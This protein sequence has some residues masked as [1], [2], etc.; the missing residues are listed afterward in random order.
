M[1]THREAFLV[2][3]NAGDAPVTRHFDDYYPM[4]CN[5]IGIFVTAG[6]G[7]EVVSLGYIRK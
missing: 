5:D 2:A 6:H 7:H 3:Y 1:H 4:L